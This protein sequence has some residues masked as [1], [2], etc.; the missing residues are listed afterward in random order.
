LFQ[1][2]YLLTPMDHVTLPHANS[3]I[4]RSTACVLASRQQASGDI[5]STMLHR[6]TAVGY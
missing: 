6:P 4:S 2:V 5:V 3:A 1:Q